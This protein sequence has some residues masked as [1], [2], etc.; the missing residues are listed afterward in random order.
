MTTV[1][2]F[3]VVLV[4]SFGVLLYFLRPTATESAVQ[5]QLA[6]IDADRNAAGQASIVREQTF[7]SNPLL[8]HLL[9]DF[10]GTQ[11]TQRLINQ[12]GQKW[13]VGTVMMGC[14]LALLV[15]TW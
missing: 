6:G 10:P 2:L 15:G 14:L 12:A 5:E 7:S 11:A 4:L 1:L 9:R 3:V 8:N 13:Q